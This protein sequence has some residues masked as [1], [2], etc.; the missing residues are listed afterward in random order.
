MT[1]VIQVSVTRDSICAAEE[2]ELS[3]S[4]CLTLSP[5]HSTEELLVSL[6][7]AFERPT[8]GIWIVIAGQRE[9]GI[10]L[11]QDE[12]LFGV[13][14]VE[15]G[16]LPRRLDGGL[17]IHLQLKRYSRYGLEQECARLGA[18]SVEKL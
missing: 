7:R 9:I 2:A 17:Q 4:E 13:N 11:G 15:L 5:V 3:H 18:V 14:G 10:L 1:S 8:Y 12:P 6:G 16:E